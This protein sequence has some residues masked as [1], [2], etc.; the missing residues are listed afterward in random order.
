MENSNS[1]EED[2]W[3][4]IALYD[5]KTGNFAEA[6]KACNQ[7]LSINDNYTKVWILLCILHQ[8]MGN[9]A[10]ALEA[11]NKI[12]DF[13]ITENEYWIEIALEFKKKNDLLN[14]VKALENSLEFNDQKKESLTELAGVYE[15]LEIYDKAY[16]FY[17]TALNMDPL[18]MDLL[19]KIGTIYDNAK[20]TANSRKKKKKKKK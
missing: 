13:D 8:K 1:K 17:K 19:N 18:D 7:I 4:D 16:T 5:K 14:V 2:S 9:D 15:D 3:Y 6:L 12:N 10:K 11:L 20:E